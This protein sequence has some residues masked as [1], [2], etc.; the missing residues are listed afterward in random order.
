MPLS[1]GSR[2]ADASAL[3]M[4]RRPL[5]GSRPENDLGYHPGKE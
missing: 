3:P 2:G 5:R 1:G 4:V